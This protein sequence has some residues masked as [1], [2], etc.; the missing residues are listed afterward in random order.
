PRDARE[1]RPRST[2][3][4]RR[5]NRW[6][7]ARKQCRSSFR[8]CNRMETELALAGSRGAR[9]SRAI[10][11]GAAAFACMLVGCSRVDTG[12]L[13]QPRSGGATTVHEINRNAF[14]RPA[15]NLDIARRVE[16]FIGNAFFNSVWIVAPA[17]ANARYGLGPLFNARSCD[18]CHNND[19]RGAPPLTP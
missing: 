4:M 16:F 6:R 17:T 5:V 15:A 3:C 7:A 14:S 9:A 13:L 11:V 2:R 1:C 12:E 10:A 18:Q 19:G 8:R